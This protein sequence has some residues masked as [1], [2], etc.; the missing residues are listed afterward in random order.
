LPLV[1]A[2]R[3]QA[4][5]VAEVGQQNLP[6][7]ARLAAAEVAENGAVG[8]NGQAGEAAGLVAVLAELGDPEAVAELGRVGEI[9]GDV[10]TGHRAGGDG[11]GGGDGLG[12]QPPLESKLM[13]VGLCSPVVA[14][15]LRREAAV[16]TGDVP[17]A[18]LGGLTKYSDWVC[19]LPSES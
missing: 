3:N 18:G 15:D 6:H 2:H 7:R 19:G 13:V 5:G 17:F 11:V 9:D 4:V 16:E 1:A 12:E 14:L 8:L 10:Q